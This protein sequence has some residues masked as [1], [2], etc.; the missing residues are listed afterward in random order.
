[1]HYKFLAENKEIVAVCING[2]IGRKIC[3]KLGGALE[4]MT[5]IYVDSIE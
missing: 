3:N 5:V 4:N 2:E 1:M